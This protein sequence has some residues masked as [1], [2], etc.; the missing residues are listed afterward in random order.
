MSTNTTVLGDLHDW[1]AWSTGLSHN[2]FSLIECAK[3]FIQVLD[4]AVLSHDNAQQYL[5]HLQLEKL[6]EQPRPSTPA[7]RPQESV[8]ERAAHLAW[9]SD[10]DD[11]DNDSD[12]VFEDQ[13][14]DASSTVGELEMDEDR[15]VSRTVTSDPIGADMRR[16]LL[17]TRPVITLHSDATRPFM[18]LPVPEQ[19]NLRNQRALQRLARQ[20]TITPLA[21][22]DQRRREDQDRRES[23]TNRSNF[24]AALHSTAS[25][26]I[27]SAYQTRQ[28][29]HIAGHMATTTITKPTH[30]H[31]GA[32][33]S[34]SQSGARSRQG[35]LIDHPENLEIPP[36]RSPSVPEGRDRED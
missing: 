18:A 21:L 27:Q 15:D 10:S 2:V 14:S 35:S 32:F 9:D 25:H 26:D 33:N 7:F 22:V 3:I 19:T 17:M 16:C 31:Y 20:V 1:A 5:Y 12:D 34:V 8:I 28:S 30:I 6:G 23:F 36:S 24:N 29:A 4:W 11:Y 13:G